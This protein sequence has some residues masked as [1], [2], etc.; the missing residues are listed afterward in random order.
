MTPTDIA[1]D[2]PMS[3]EEVDKIFTDKLS[4]LQHYR[5]DW[6]QWIDDTHASRQ[7]D[8]LIRRSTR[9][10]VGTTHAEPTVCNLIGD[11]ILIE[12]KHTDG[13]V[14]E[15][16]VDV[17]QRNVVDGSTVDYTESPPDSDSHFRDL[18]ELTVDSGAV[19]WS[20]SLLLSCRFTAWRRGPYNENVYNFLKSLCRANRTE[21]DTM[22]VAA[23]SSEDI[24]E[25]MSRSGISSSNAG[26][27]TEMQILSLRRN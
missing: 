6:Q 1:V 10:M 22:K 16:F 8:P 7:R 13:S 26:A 23:S 5:S 14:L 4:Y 19:D 27:P 25:P 11:P 9:C 2:H 21:A 20:N 15:I 3:S 24:P 17:A 12:A 18:L